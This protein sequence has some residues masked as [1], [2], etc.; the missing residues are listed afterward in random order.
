ME[1]TQFDVGETYDLTALGANSPLTAIAAV[2]MTSGLASSKLTSLA[3]QGE[4]P[5][6][7]MVV[8]GWMIFVVLPAYRAAVVYV[9]RVVSSLAWDVEKGKEFVQPRVVMSVVMVQQV[10]AYTAA[11][12]AVAVAVAVV[13]AVKQLLVTQAGMRAVQH[14]HLWQA[15]VAPVQIPHAQFVH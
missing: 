3:A 10:L 5:L 2:L 12:V 13:A 4:A 1:G 14:I 11:A 7:K 9:E 15:N 6:E 8:L